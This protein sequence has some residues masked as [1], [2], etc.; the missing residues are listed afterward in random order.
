MVGLGVLSVFGGTYDMVTIRGP[1]PGC[2]I[3]CNPIQTTARVVRNRVLHA[4]LVLLRPVSI[5]TVCRPSDDEPALQ[6]E[7]EI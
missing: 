1:Y 4:R 6:R 7:G 2:I 5:N 3:I